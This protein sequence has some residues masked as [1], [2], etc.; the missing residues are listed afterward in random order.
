MW[1]SALACAGPD[2]GCGAQAEA[3]RYGPAPVRRGR[4]SRAGGTTGGI[5]KIQNAEG[6]SNFVVDILNNQ[7]RN[8]AYSN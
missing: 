4:Q 2:E 7:N 3:L 6:E 5:L 8:N 1:R